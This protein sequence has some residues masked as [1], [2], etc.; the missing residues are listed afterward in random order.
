MDSG[1]QRLPNRLALEW[2]GRRSFVTV[3]GRSGDVRFV[4]LVG[5][6]WFWGSTYRWVATEELDARAR[7]LRSKL[8][9]DLDL[10]E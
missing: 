9:S 4:Q 1:S 3:T 6:S 8:I 5:A 7:G 2:E 10:R